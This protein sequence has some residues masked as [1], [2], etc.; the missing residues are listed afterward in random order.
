MSTLGPNN[1]CISQEKKKVLVLTFSFPGSEVGDVL[2]HVVVCLGSTVAIPLSPTQLI[3]YQLNLL[4]V[5]LGQGTLGGKEK[6]KEA[7]RFSLTQQGTS[8][9]YYSKKIIKA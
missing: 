9:F 7:I 2:N 1:G 4:Q 8:T 3:Q 5:K 6:V